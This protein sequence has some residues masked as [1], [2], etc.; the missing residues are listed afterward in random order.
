MQ[1]LEPNRANV[2]TPID[3]KKLFKTQQVR[4]PI[5]PAILAAIGHRF[6]A[7]Q[8]FKRLETGD[9]FFG[10]KGKWA[11]YKKCCTLFT[12]NFVFMFL[13]FYL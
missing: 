4:I 13:F 10:L 8:E 5:D 3:V 11:F 12:N 7:K 1:L 6:I 9:F 2:H